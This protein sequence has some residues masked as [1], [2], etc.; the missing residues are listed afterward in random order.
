MNEMSMKRSHGVG[1]QKCFYI[2]F[3]LIISMYQF[4]LARLL[5]VSKAGLEW[6]KSA[7][8]QVFE[9]LLFYFLKR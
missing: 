5:S 1:L 7:L 3:Q 6:S 4:G 8:E 9:K 2:E